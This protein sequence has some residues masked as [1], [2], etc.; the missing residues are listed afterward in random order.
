MNKFL[1]AGCAAAILVLLSACGGGGGGGDG[2]S[3]SKAASAVQ[4]DP[5]LTSA[6]MSFSAAALE[7]TA[8]EGDQAQVNFSASVSYQG[9]SPFWVYFNEEGS[10]IATGDISPMGQGFYGQ[11]R[12]VDNLA[13]GTYTSELVGHLCEDDQCAKEL[14]NG[15]ARL[16][17][18]YTVKPN[19]HAP[20]ELTLRRQG[21]DAAPAQTLDVEVPA[22][23]GQ[24]TASLVT[25]TADAMSVSFDG[26]RLTVQTKEVRAGTYKGTV[27]LQGAADVRYRKAVNVTYTVDPPAGGEVALSVDQN[28]WSLNLHQGDTFTK[29]IKITRPSWTT[30][31][32]APTWTAPS[33]MFQLKDLGN[34]EY[35][36]VAS[37]VGLAKGAYSAALRFNA[38]P[39]GGD[40]HV[41]LFAVVDAAFVVGKQGRY[42]VINV[43][44]SS[45]ETALTA[46]VPVT[47][48]DGIAAGWRAVSKSPWIKFVQ[49]SGTTGVDPIRVQV[50]KAYLPQLLGLQEGAFEV[51]IN[52]PGT[53]VQLMSVQFGNGIQILKDVG[54][55]SLVGSKGRVY[56]AGNF[57]EY[58]DWSKLLAE[59][60]L[61]V[62][63][64]VVDKVSMVHDTR[65]LDADARLVL[66][67]SSAQVGQPVDISLH[68]AFMNSQVR[69]NVVAAKAL[70]VGYVA[71]PYGHYRPAQYIPALQRLYWAGEGQ[72]FAFSHGDTMWQLSQVAVP[73]SVDLAISSDEK[74]LYVVAGRD[75][76]AYDP[77]SLLF[78]R[79]NGYALPYGG[80]ESDADAFDAQVPDWGRALVT[81][82]DGR[83]FASLVNHRYAVSGNRGVAWITGGAE[84]HPHYIADLTDSPH[85]GEPGTRTRSMEGHHSGSAIVRSAG[86]RTLVAVDPD[87]VAWSYSADEHAGWTNMGTLPVGVGL[88]AVND[89]GTLVLRSDGRLQSAIGQPGSSLAAKLPPTYVAG[90]YGLTGD[91]RFALIYG[92]RLE[93]QAD[94]GQ[95]ARDASVWAVDLRGLAV[96]QWDAATVLGRMVLPN[97]VGCTTAP[98]AGERCIHQAAVTVDPAGLNIFVTG[99]R[100]VVAMALPTAWVEGTAAASA[101]SVSTG[102][103]SAQAVSP[104]AKTKVRKAFSIGVKR[105]GA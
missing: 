91:G 75:V 88:A 16:P 27:V 47:T 40:V 6:T 51:S 38:G 23:A 35:E 82:A 99:P 87:G 90:G 61:R 98:E 79:R 42:V 1:K 41:S 30:G 59:G 5:S 49:N 21:R 4:A 76:L 72:V 103:A 37:A 55:A 52:R 3:D 45:D 60:R 11:L 74:S 68:S 20:S 93:D 77:L 50:D 95:R 89:A 26:T 22:D 15:R 18:R 65:L 14:P 25:D 10:L 33:P 19:I 94:G 97:A 100:G 34:D 7:V 58:T 92:Y 83:S 9:S 2:G 67:L 12:L 105:G 57:Y 69:V 46:S 73:Q 78:L 31:W 104:P 53:D 48:S 85:S 8:I 32:T 86:G 96:G 17:L 63:G 71:L 84:L 102:R 56:V 24:V 70:P 80:T 13:P 101:A 64:A 62:T 44:E 81:M 36:I 66:D 43:D 29:R 39:T 28:A 54:S